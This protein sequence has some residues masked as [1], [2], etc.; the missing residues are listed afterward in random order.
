MDARYLRAPVS[1]AM[2][3]RSPVVRSTALLIITV[4]ALSCAAPEQRSTPANQ[5]AAGGGNA[6][7]SGRVSDPHGGPVPDVPIQAKNK[8]TG[9]AARTFSSADGRY[10]LANL[11]A[12]K[13]ALSIS[14]PCCALRPFS[15]DDVKIE[16]SENVQLDIQ[17]EEGSSLNT[18]G[19]DPGTLASIVRN[20]AKVPAGPPPRTV[21]GKPDLSGVWLMNED[22]FPEGPP[23][24]PWAAAL[25]K[26][27]IANEAK[28]HP[29]SRCLPGGPPIPFSVPPFMTKFIQTPNL[30]V[31]LFEDVPGFRQVFVDGRSHPPEPDPTWVGHSIGKW[32]GDTLV[33]DTTGYNDRGWMGIYPR[34]EKLRVVERYKRIDFGHLEVE[35]TVEDPGVFDK[36]WKM[37]MRWDL[38]PQEEIQ[39]IVCEN[40]KFLENIQQ[41]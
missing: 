7:L 32:E 2:P 28:D 22:P 26:E 9:I 10:T 23:A 37:N 36:R 34:T 6:S 3:N 21:D 35:V 30:M 11:G 25:A 38:V 17:L 27:R 4:T 29:H 15:K 41:K 24:Q 14:A 12:G 18:I 31:I 13:Y 19:D 39:E 40:N 33:I 20:R 1:L 8:E 16:S 5:L